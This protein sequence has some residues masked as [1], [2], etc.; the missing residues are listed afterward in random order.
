MPVWANFFQEW[1]PA[2]QRGKFPTHKLLRL[3]Y[4]RW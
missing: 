1:M 4:C 3:L 2:F